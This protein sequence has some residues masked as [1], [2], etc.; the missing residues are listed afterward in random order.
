[1]AVGST[2]ARHALVVAVGAAGRVGRPP[3]GADRPRLLRAEL[4]GGELLLSG[5]LDGRSARV[6]HDAVSDL[7]RTGQSSWTVDATRL[8]VTDHG[9]LR[10]LV[11]CYQRA[12]EHD[13]VVT[14][15]GASPA[16][17][18]ALRRLRLDVH[19]LLDEAG[20]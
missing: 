2:G 7:L 19:L 17:R 20:P 11:G 4:V 1:V 13:C 3:V 14:V 16:L 9:G 8:V 5:R 6:L 12:V 10:A 18:H 15:H